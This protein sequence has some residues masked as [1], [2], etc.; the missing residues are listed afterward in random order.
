MVAKYVY[1]IHYHDERSNG[2]MRTYS[3]EDSVTIVEML[4]RLGYIIDELEIR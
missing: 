4:E 1:Y 3:E 2:V